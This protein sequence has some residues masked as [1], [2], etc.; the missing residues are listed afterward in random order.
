[1]NKN[2]GWLFL[3]T[4]ILI[5]SASRSDAAGLGLYGSFGR[6]SADWKDEYTFSKFSTDTQ[7]KA[8]GITFDSNLSSD[9]IFNYHLEIGRDKFTTKNFI[10][11]NQTGT[12]LVTSDIDLAGMIMSHAFGFG[13]QVSDNVRM[14]LGPE[15]RFY[16]VKGAPSKAADFDL[17]GSGLGVGP[18]LGMNVNL[19][20]GLTIMLKAGYSITRYSLDGAGY[21]NNTYSSNYYD[22]DEWFTYL[23]LEFLFRTRGER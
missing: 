18:S 5:F 16:R 21:I 10:A 9:R 1:M 7:H 13:G 4:M 20:S 15:I 11:R 6:G 14:W 19:S 17:D 8:F 2:S 22:V 23:N 12:P 3:C